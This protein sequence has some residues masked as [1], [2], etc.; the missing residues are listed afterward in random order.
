MKIPVIVINGILEAGKTWFLNDAIACETFID[1]EAR[2]LILQCESGEVEFDED[3]MV[4]HNT[5]VYTFED[6]SE[7]TE[8]KIG[9]LVRKYHPDIIYVESNEMWDW[10]T[11]GLP[12]FTY[13][14][15]QITVIDASTFKIYFNNM[16][17]KFV[18]ML[19]DS[20]I[21]MMNR[22]D[23]EKSVSTFRRNLKLINP[24]LMFMFFDSN[25]NSVTL[26]EDLPYSLEG[27]PIILSD[28]DYGVWYIDTFE[29][30]ARY[31][32]KRV[33]FL[34]DCRT[35]PRLPKDYFVASRRVMTCCENDIRDFAV[36]CHNNTTTPVK[37]RFWAYLTAETVYREI[38][39][40]LQMH[41]EVFKITETDAPDKPVIGLN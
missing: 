16:R 14:E 25:N 5:V 22:C 28:E 27:N 8:E 17:Q 35:D 40:E 39:G 23:D 24:N 3:N 10:K 30:P 41:L 19:E 11:I 21:V 20:E 32:G 37:N 2:G 9:E 1:P 7:F 33:R 15:Q 4:A 31:R 26:S 18:D 38:G 6:Q 34:A 36:A 13:V 12:S 29:S